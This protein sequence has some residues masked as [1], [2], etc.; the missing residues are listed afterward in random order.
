M[1]ND[2]AGTEFTISPSSID[3]GGNAFNV[4][5]APL[6]TPTSVSQSGYQ[7][8]FQN[9]PFDEITLTPP[10]LPPAQS[11]AKGAAQ[12]YINFCKTIAG[13]VAAFLGSAI[14]FYGR[15]AAPSPAEADQVLGTEAAALEALAN[16]AR[17]VTQFFQEDRQEH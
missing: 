5:S 8:K 1:L 14:T 3:I 13:P 6:P 2:A 12:D 11:V 9:R 10:D 15:Y 16:A 4:P 7:V 17:N